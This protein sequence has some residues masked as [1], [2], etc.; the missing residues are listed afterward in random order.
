MVAISP[1]I[2]DSVIG[3]NPDWASVEPAADRLERVLARRCAAVEDW[4]DLCRARTEHT[5]AK[6][7]GAA[8]GEEKA[9][10]RCRMVGMT[11]SGA[12]LY[13]VPLLL[14]I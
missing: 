7:W 9:L 11:H 3:S 2:R 13:W 6:T 5:P 10:H 14:A 1:G 4:E 12:S 8:A